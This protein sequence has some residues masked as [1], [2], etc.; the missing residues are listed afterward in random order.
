MPQSAKRWRVC[1][2]IAR[3]PNCF[4]LSNSRE[5]GTDVSMRDHT[6]TTASV[7][8]VKLLK[9][10]KVTDPAESA[11]SGATLTGEAGV[12]R[13]KQLS[14]I[15]HTASEKCSSNSVGMAWGS[16]SI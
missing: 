13:H 12:V 9:L 11:G 10:P 1:S 6:A 8:L 4:V 16:P 7:I 5:F 14:G 15:R 2:Q 3:S